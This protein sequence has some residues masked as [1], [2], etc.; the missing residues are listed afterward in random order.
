[1]LIIVSNTIQSKLCPVIKTIWDDQHQLEFV[2]TIVQ[3]STIVY[4]LL[5][6]KQRLNSLLLQFVTVYFIKIKLAAY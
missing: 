1:M 6:L 5:D 4:Q 3:K 2:D